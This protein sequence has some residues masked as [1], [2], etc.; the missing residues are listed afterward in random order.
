MSDAYRVSGGPDRW[1]NEACFVSSPEWA[2]LD[3]LPIRLKT[4]RIFLPATSLSLF[5]SLCQ[6]GLVPDR[7]QSSRKRTVFSSARE[8]T[9][10]NAAPSR[11]SSL[12][13]NGVIPSPRRFSRATEPGRCLN[14]LF[15]RLSLKL[16]ESAMTTNEKSLRQNRSTPKFIIRFKS[17]IR[18][19]G[20]I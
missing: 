12:Y 7:Y 10:R 13:R 14:V 15:Q 11:V 5:L 18:L 1:R 19:F 8:R 17:G 20:Q 16:T 6:N 3:A 2:Q 9:E 4:N